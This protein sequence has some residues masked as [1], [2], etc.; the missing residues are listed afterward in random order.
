[1]YYQEF[2]LKVKSNVF[3]QQNKEYLLELVQDEWEFS[4]FLRQTE[5]LFG[6][7]AYSVIRYST[8]PQKSLSASKKKA[9]ERFG[10]ELEASLELARYSLGELHSNSS[11]DKKEIR[12]LSALYFISKLYFL[13]VA[14]LRKFYSIQPHREGKSI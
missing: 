4:N 9:I 10:L 3:I 11:A 2:F 8:A 6:M 1:M 13:I 14:F 7:A 5:H 12:L